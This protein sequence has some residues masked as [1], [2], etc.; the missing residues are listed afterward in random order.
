MTF[1]FQLLIKRR[2]LF[3]SVSI[4]ALP[5]LFEP[6]PGLSQEGLRVLSIA[7][8]S[9]LL[10]ITEPVPLPTVALLIAVLQVLFKIGSPADVAKSF[11]SDSVFFIM[12]SL[13]LAVAIVKQKLDKRIAL[14]ILHITGPKVYRIA[15]GLAIVSA[16]IASVAGEHTVAA[17]MLP[18]VLTLLTFT[19]SEPQKIRNLSILLLL[20]VAYGAMIAGIGTPSGGARNAI[21]IAYFNHL[22]NLHIGYLMWI[23]YIYPFLL[24]QVPLVTYLLYKTFKP[25][26]MD[27]TQAISQLQEKVRGEG[28]LTQKD[29]WTIAIFLFTMLL[30]ITVSDEIGLGITALIGVCLYLLFD[31]VKWEDLNYG[32]NWGVILIYASAISLG[33]A[34]KNSGATDWMATSIL[35]VINPNGTHIDLLILGVISLL[36]LTV[37]SFISS[38][39][40]VGILGPIALDMARLAGISVMAAGFVTVISSS[41]AFMTPIASPA[42]QIVYATGHLR[43]W[44]FLRGGWKMVL[45][46]LGLLLLFSQ[47]YWRLVGLP[48]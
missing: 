2:W 35:G 38:G 39:A 43:K 47:T 19:S 11:M 10:F 28:K 37:A 29:G 20:S 31:I 44:D 15:F 14:V 45:V 21:M 5:F 9:I 41:F 4:G 8:V 22:Y 12:G 36:T 42:C 23:E 1:L 6:P 7:G 33:I 3:I 27:L 26:V 34:M 32:V 40:T 46:S 25:E 18:V 30:W 48:R 17:M 24:I 13:M 16:F